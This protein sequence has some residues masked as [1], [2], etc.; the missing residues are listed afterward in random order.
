MDIVTESKKYFF[1][2][3]K[4]LPLYI[5]HGKGVYLYDKEGMKY[6]DCLSG[7][8]VNLLGYVHP[9]VNEAIIEQLKKH[10]HLSNFFVQD[11]VLELAKALIQITGYNK[12]FFSNSGTEAIDGI[13]KLVK[14]W[15]KANGKDDIEFIAIEGAFHG[16]SIGG[17]S[18]T[19]QEKYQKDYK[20]LLPGVRGIQF[21][22]VGQLIETASS[23]TSAVFIEFIQGEGG[24][25]PV[26]RD[27]I[28]KLKDLQQKYNFLIIADEIQTGLG[29]TGKF[30][31]FEH[32]DIKPDIVAIAKGLGGGLPLGAILGN[33]KVAES[34]NVSDHGTTC[35]GNAVAAAAGIAV[36]DEL[37][38][39]GVM[40]NA[41][42]VGKYFV[43]KLQELKSKYQ[44]FI[45]EVRGKGLMLGVEVKD[46][47]QDVLNES[48]KDGLI[49]NVTAG[50]TLRLLPPLIFT[51]SNVDE[52]I[53]IL[54][55]VIGRIIGGES[56]EMS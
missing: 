42:E 23:K 15:A 1:N 16:R 50:N 39:N 28:A 46:K 51:K 55:D 11:K 5:D 8:G 30:F 13:I 52:V 36:I 40:Q 21:N 41:L 54:D 9:K 20:P 17:L 53:E 26:S 33:E 48:L 47:A 34:W 31:G 18:L 37:I 35:G 19:I 38:D 24:V 27:L 25:R 22:N 14:R 56:A 10:S 29:R 7:L 45:V 12:V 4:R 32:F 3:F 2:V 6:I 49:L 44:D 43:E